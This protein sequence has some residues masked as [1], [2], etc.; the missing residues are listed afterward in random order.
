MLICEVSE[1]EFVSPET[2]MARIHSQ[3]RS[4]AMHH[5]GKFDLCKAR[6]VSFVTQLKGSSEKVLRCF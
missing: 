1:L 4:M 2:A 3:L 5:G 6:V